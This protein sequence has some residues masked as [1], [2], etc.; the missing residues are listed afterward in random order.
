[1]KKRWT[2]ITSFERIIINLY[3]LLSTPFTCLQETFVLSPFSVSYKIK[4][5]ISRLSSVAIVRQLSNFV[6]HVNGES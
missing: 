1:M 4:V 6:I 3:I 5:C 2:E